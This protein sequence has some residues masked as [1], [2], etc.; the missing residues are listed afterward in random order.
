M[1]TETSIKSKLDV[2]KDFYDTTYHKYSTPPRLISGHHRNLAER[3][4]LRPG[5]KVLDVACGTGEWLLA[6]RQRG[7]IVNGVDIS[8]KAIDACREAMPDAEFV[9]A[10][11]EA[12]PFPE[13]TFDI[14]TCL[15]A[16]EHFV[17]AEAALAEMIRVGKPDARFVILVPNSGFLTRRL[18]LFRGTN[19]A[20]VKEEVL[21]LEE[22]RDMFEKAGLVVNQCWADLHVLSQAWIMSGSWYQWPIRFVQALMLLVWPL[23]WQYQVFYLCGKKI[24]L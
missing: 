9:V 12:L 4:A 7:V 1:P 23:R 18:G 13:Q 2:I 10:P 3:L 16:L 24:R 5:Q 19:Q 8:D 17:D 21:S 6:T 15:G 14:V 11:A 22:W 20:M